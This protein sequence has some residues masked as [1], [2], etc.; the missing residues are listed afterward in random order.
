MSNYSNTFLKDK[1]YSERWENFFAEKLGYN[2]NHV[3][4]D[5]H[6]VDL[7]KHERIIDVK[8]YRPPIHGEY[9]G[10]FIET[11]LPL[12][13]MVG[14]FMDNSK[15]NNGYILVKDAKTESYEYDK[16]WMI[17]KYDL[18][19]AVAEARRDAKDAGLKD[20]EVKKTPSG[21]GIILEYKY[22]AKYGVEV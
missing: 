13:N 18:S 4:G 19:Q 6:G 9:K 8:A 2:T 1:E 21:W 20:L 7:T 10:F 14:W 22:V 15:L 17:T 16:A 5:D 3:K 12:S 11:W